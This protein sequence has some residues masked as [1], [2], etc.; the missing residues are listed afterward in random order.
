MTTSA[1]VSCSATCYKLTESRFLMPCSRKGSTIV[2]PYND[3]TLE[4]VELGGSVFVSA[5]KNMW[6]AVDEYGFERMK[7]END[8]DVMGIWDGEKFVLTVGSS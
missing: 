7:F 1:E 6:R 4:P 3:P 2:Q 5:N 8:E